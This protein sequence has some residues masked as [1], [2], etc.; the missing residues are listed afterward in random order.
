M[1]WHK[2]QL[3]HRDMEYT[4]FLCG[5]GEAGD[6]CGGYRVMSYWKMSILYPDVE[7][8]PYAKAFNIGFDSIY[9]ADIEA[10]YCIIKNLRPA[11]ST[12]IFDYIGPD[13][14]EAFS[15]GFDSLPSDMESYLDGSFSYAFDTAFDIAYG[16]SFDFDTFDDSFRKPN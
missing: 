4:P 6:P 15:S 14:D 12:V 9:S 8:G 11:H 3:L 16:G 13:F 10:L 2:D 7:A 5:I 1:P